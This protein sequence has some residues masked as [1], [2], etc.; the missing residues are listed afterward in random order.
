[1]RKILR[2][3]LNKAKNGD[4]IK[5]TKEEIEEINWEEFKKHMEEYKPKHDQVCPHCGRCPVCG[6]WLWPTPHGPEPC[7]GEW[8][9]YH[10]L[11]P[12][13]WGVGY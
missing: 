2:D 6:R 11:P 10:I 4:A 5:V 8:R 9:P 1:M 3:K 12:E 13:R 7:H